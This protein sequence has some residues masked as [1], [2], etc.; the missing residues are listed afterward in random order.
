MGH[1]F[2]FSSVFLPWSPPRRHQLNTQLPSTTTAFDD[3]FLFTLGLGHGRAEGAWVWRFAHLH[4]SDFLDF[5]TSG[6][7]VQT[8]IRR[9]AFGRL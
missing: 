5:V 3:D 1:R 2:A 7:G 4:T 9:G 6:S 8:C